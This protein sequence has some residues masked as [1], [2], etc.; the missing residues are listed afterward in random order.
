[1]LSSDRFDTQVCEKCGMLAYKGWCKGCGDGE[2]ISSITIP[3]AA[4]LMMQEVSSADG[5]PCIDADVQ[6]MAMNIMPKLCLEDTV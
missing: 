4:K 3:Y 6:L 2:S 5:R 1:M